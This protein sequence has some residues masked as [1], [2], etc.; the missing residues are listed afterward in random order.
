MAQILK[1]QL[2]CN[3]R[4]KKE[5]TERKKL[6]FDLSNKG[7]FNGPLTEEE[8]DEALSECKRSSP[9]QDEIYYEFLKKMDRKA[10]INLLCMKTYG[11]KKTSQKNRRVRQ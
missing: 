7:S 1:N 5:E 6:N 10:R 4:K 11:A 2:Q 8:L 9:G 3:F